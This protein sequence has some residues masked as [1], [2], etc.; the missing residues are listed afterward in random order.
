[1][2]NFSLIGM[3][4]VSKQFVNGGIRKLLNYHW[5][6]VKV[7]DVTTILGKILPDIFSLRTAVPQS[8][9]R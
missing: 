4:K 7:I 1:M 5:N 6:Q 2:F 8:N 9:R 3:W